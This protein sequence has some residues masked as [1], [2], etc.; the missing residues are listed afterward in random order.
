VRTVKGLRRKIRRGG[1]SKP[2]PGKDSK[3]IGSNIFQ[4]EKRL[5]DKTSRKPQSQPSKKAAPK[6]DTSN[7]KDVS[8][9]EEKKMPEKKTLENKK[10]S[11]E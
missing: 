11:P 7:Y 8:A 9:P 6:K 4:E 3:T 1:S 5:L 10:G 2:I